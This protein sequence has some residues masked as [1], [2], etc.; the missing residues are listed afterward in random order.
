MSRCQHGKSLEGRSRRSTIQAEEMCMQA[1]SWKA[2]VQETEA[3]VA[4]SAENE[5]HG[6]QR[7]KK[8]Q[9]QTGK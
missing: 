7:E 8:L 3:R 1:L 6:A 4:W 5:K 9:E 2:S